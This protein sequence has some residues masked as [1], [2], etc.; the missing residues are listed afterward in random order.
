[1]HLPAKRRPRN[2]D[3]PDRQRA[4]RAD[5][6]AGRARAPVRQPR[7]RPERGGVPAL[8]ELQ[9]ARQPDHDRA[10]HRGG[11]CA[12]GRRAVSRCAS[13]RRTGIPHNSP[14][15]TGST[16]PARPTATSHSASASTRAPGSTSRASRAASPSVVSWRASGLSARRRPGARRPRP[17]P[18]LRAPEGG[19]HAASSGP[20]RAAG[21]RTCVR[22]GRRRCGPGEDRCRRIGD[23]PRGIA[24]HSR[25]E[26]GRHVS[27]GD[28]RQ[29]GG[30]HRPGR[31]NRHDQCRA[32]D[33]EAHWRKPG[34]RDHRH[35]ARRRRRAG[36]DRRHRRRRD[37]DDIAGIVHPHHRSRGC[38]E[39]VDVQDAADRRDD[40]RRDRGAH[41]RTGVKTIGYIGFN[42]ALG[43][44]FFAEVDKAAKARGVPLVGNERFAPKDTSVVGQTLKV[45]VAKPDVDR[46]RARARPQRCRRE[47]SL[48]RGYKG[49][50]YLQPRRGEQRFPSRR[51]KGRRG[52]LRAG[53]P[54]DRRGAAP[55][56]PSVQ[57]LAQEYVRRVRE[58]PYGPGSVAAFGSYAW[59]ACLELAYAIPARSRARSRAP[60]SSAARCATRWRHQGTGRHQRR[61]QHEARPTTSGST[62]GRA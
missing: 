39:G 21:A 53:E 49:K 41:G 18:R 52:R 2:D 40:G 10:R 42:D 11:R 27:E 3:Q 55:R 44:A 9:P 45:I 15:P 17:V 20:L 59:D 4:P 58:R 48:S 6:V 56:L 47:R 36:D 61:C 1:M 12:A 13:V 24:R 19:T 50:L 35:R 28:R 43:E 14:H 46:D 54:R 23:R 31:C 57:K 32:G 26:H 25:E 29:D 62:H 33:Q 38:E 51:R 34:R 5:A 37:A 30:L 60:G 7:S 22:C 16:S 8:R